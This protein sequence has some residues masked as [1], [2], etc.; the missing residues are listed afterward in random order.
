MGEEGLWKL[1]FLT[2]LPEVYLELKVRRDRP[3]RP[4][5]EP[6]VTAFVS[7]PVGETEC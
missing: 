1:F 6:A 4:G 3:D 2:G 7:R 5:E